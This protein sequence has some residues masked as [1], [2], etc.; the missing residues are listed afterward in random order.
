[1]FTVEKLG[2]EASVGEFSD[3]G[4]LVSFQGLP[5]VSNLGEMIFGYKHTGDALEI[6]ETAGE[7]SSMGLLFKLRAP[8]RLALKNWLCPRVRLGVAAG[9]QAKLTRVA[10]RRSARSSW[11]S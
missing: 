11:L 5:L 4:G 7:S 6:P 8:P 10:F 9:S 2:L 1:M 3:G